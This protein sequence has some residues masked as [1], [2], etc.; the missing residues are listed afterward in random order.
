MKLRT[1]SLYLVT[2]AILASLSGCARYKAQPLKTLRMRPQT[3]QSLSFEYRVFTIA[4]CAQYLDRNVIG[5]GYQPIQI[6]FSNNTTHYIEISPNSFSFPCAGPREVAKLVHTDTTAR[7][8]GYTI[9]GVF[10][11]PFL[12]PALV[13]GLWSSKAN[14]LLDADFT[15]KSLRNQTIK[16]Y[17][18]FNGIIF[19]PC[20]AFDESFILTVTDKQSNAIYTLTP[21][22][23]T[24]KL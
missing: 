15:Q 6:S 14:K 11:W 24:I 2:V 12:I 1:L 8:A 3:E 17:S 4:D 21:E 10:I 5:E 13:D 23:H 19:V 16:P 22:N 20:D 9:A 18:V 7:V